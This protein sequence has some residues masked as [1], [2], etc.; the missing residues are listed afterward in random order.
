MSSAGKMPAMQT[1]AK[2][3]INQLK[4]VATQTGDVYISIVPFNKD[5]AVAP[6]NYTE[7]WVDWE[8]WD[9]VNGTCNIS[10]KTTEATCESGV[11]TACSKPQYTTKKKCQ[12]NGGTWLSTGGVWTPKAH[13]TWN[14]CITDRDKDPVGT[15]D[16]DTKN[17]APNPLVPSTL[18]P[19]EQYASC[20]SPVMALSYD[21]TALTNKINDLVPAGNT[22]QGIGLAWGWQTLT[23]APFTIPPYDSAFQYKKVIILLSDGL[24][25]ENRWYTS[26]AS[27]NARQA[28]TCTNVKATGVVVY[29]VQVN[30]GGDPT[31]T[32][33][34]NCATDSSKFFMLTSGS[35][36][37]TTFQQIATELANMHLSH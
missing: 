28:I 30:T 26:A 21:W 1:A 37:I 11:V 6:S 35:Q 33:L 19:A 4:A 12:N 36:I 5:V 8:D 13:S 18:F 31:S 29:T 10:G 9:A 23:S 24:N 7:S 34:Q 2:N 14:G 17:T 16:Y 3:L 20:P 25:T 32:V 22:N 27:I 15:A